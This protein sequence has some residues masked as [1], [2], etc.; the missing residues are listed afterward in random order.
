MY[1][2]EGDTVIY[3]GNN[4]L[5]RS[6]AA[7]SAGEK[8]TY[9]G[10]IL[11]DDQLVFEHSP[12]ISAT[13]IGLKGE[14][15]LQ[16]IEAALMAARRFTD[17]R[18]AL[19]KA[20][21]EFTGLP[22]R[23]EELGRRQG[24]LYVNDS[25]SSAP[26]AT[27]AAVRAYKD[28]ILLIMGGYD[29]GLDLE[30]LVKELI[31]NEQLK[32]VF[33]IGQ[34]GKKLKQLFDDHGYTNAFLCE[35]LDVAFSEAQSQ[36]IAG[37]VIMLS[38]GC[39]S[40]D[41]FSDFRERGEVFRR[42]VATIR[43][44]FVFE[45]YAFHSE[46]GQASFRYSF[47]R[48]DHFEETILF[49]SAE[50]YDHTALQ[51]AL[52]LAFILVGTSYYKLYPG[53]NVELNGLTLDEWQSQ[54]FSTVYQEGMSQYAYENELTRQDLA[55]FIATG[56]SDDDASPYDGGGILALQSGGKDSL[57]TA[58]LLER[59]RH[60][61]DSFYVTSRGGYYPEF[62]ERLP[63]KLYTAQRLIDLASIKRHVHSGALSGHVPVTFIVLATSLIQAVLLNKNTIVVSIG[64]EGEEPHEMIGDLIVTHQWSK[65]WEAEQLFA[66]YVSRYI[67][68]DIQVGSPLRRFTELR[69]AELFVETSWERYGHLFSSCNVAN[70][71]QGN[72]NSSLTWC[73]ECPK[74]ANS[75]LLFAPF[76]PA[77]ELQSLFG[78]HDLF[79][80]PGLRHTFEG[81]LGINGA[82]KP[83]E[84]VGEIEELRYA[85]HLSLQR[86]G[87]AHLPFEVPQSSFDYKQHY[88]SQ[89]W[90]A[91][92]FSI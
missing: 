23:I 20:I 22:Y 41:M 8:L 77:N 7:H 48:Y 67:S 85:Y 68:E 28:P 92:L 84:C 25:F 40:F 13:A 34:T 10:A 36:A 9:T 83:F 81:L 31:N 72:D 55:Q 78:G 57:L 30:P 88:P 82:M 69:I 73:G 65:T 46:T 54:F 12:L 24:V 79:I 45:S 32:G 21:R 38:P 74:C 1:Q 14:H 62:I 26:P 27:L 42:L 5:S 43:R 64:H 6:V 50:T 89:S 87:Y 90:T 3:F 53:S 4:D 91:S 51:K 70:Y 44:D 59:S 29:R 47:D 16:N 18:E 15:N 80:K 11:D 76:L 71:T 17:D 66:N 60:A 52:K 35:E 58:R 33:L 56:R 37:D 39:A 19:A 75:Y 61:F 2:Q 49:E 86:G 63:G